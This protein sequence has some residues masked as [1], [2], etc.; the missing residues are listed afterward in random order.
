[1]TAENFIERR[2]SRRVFKKFEVIDFVLMQQGKE[3]DVPMYVHN[4][5]I[6]G[7]CCLSIKN[8]DV[9]V[10]NLMKYHDRKRLVEKSCYEVVWL[11]HLSESI[12]MVGMQ[13]KGLN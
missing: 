12:F 3:V 10:G 4:R 8:L 9:H 13:I 11:E 6:E 5:S 2:K 1:M 7:L